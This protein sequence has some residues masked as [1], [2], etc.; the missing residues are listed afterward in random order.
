MKQFLARAIFYSPM[1]L[2]GLYPIELRFFALMNV[3]LKKGEGNG[4]G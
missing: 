3:N 1:W 2:W 4:K